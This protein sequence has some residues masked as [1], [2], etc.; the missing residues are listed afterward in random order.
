MATVIGRTERAC[1]PP[2][3]L[4]ILPGRLSAELRSLDCYGIEEIRL[5]R[6]RHVYLT[7]AEGNRRLHT[8]LSGEEMSGILTRMC[9]DSLYAYRSTVNNGFVTLAGGIRVGVCG[10]A[11][12][13][14][15]SLVGIYDVSALNI[16]LPCALRT[17]GA[18]VAERLRRCEN[19]LLIYAPPGVGKT[20]LLR[21]VTM[22]LSSGQN[23]LRV[24]VIDSRGELGP[25]MEGKELMLDIFSGYPRGLG[26]EIATRTMGADLIVCDEIGS[27]EEAGAILSMQSSGVRLLATAHAADVGGLLKKPFFGELHKAHVFDAYVGIRRPKGACEYQYEITDWER[28]DDLW[29]ACG[30]HP[31][32]R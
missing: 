16:R 1:V 6:D 5:R 13:E 3:V 17:V 7:L 18:S 27:G 14:G 10:R 15:N 21:A 25:M 29:K 8:V 30:R 4:N 12:C 20:T 11:A 22:R 24:C 31:S 32:A 23:A 2:T 26:M 28:A 19:G 9:D